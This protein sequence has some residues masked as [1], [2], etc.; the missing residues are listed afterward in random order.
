MA[1]TAPTLVWNGPALLARI[2]A[3]VDHAVNDRATHIEQRL[4]AELHRWHLTPPDEHFLADEAF[5]AV[6]HV[7]DRWTLSAG[8]EAWYAIWHEL[9][10][11][12]QIRQI[13]G[14]QEGPRLAAA[15]E[16]AVRGVV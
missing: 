11:H 13:V 1:T 10:F 3:A 6:Y 4:H 8:S 16:A 2:E 14:D 15:V 12:P 9:R 7:G 5:A